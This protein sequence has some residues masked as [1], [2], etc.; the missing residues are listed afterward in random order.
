MNKGKNEKEVD[1]FGGFNLIRGEFIPPVDNN[2]EDVKDIVED[3]ITDPDKEAAIDKAIEERIRLA[4]ELKK[5]KEGKGTPKKDE[6]PE[7]DDDED[8]VGEESGIRLFARALAEKGVID[9]DDTD[10]DF[11]DAEEGLEKLVEKTINS[12]I[13]NWSSS[14]DPE[15][16][17]FYE[18]T[19]AG[20]KPQ[21]FLKV[22]YG[23]NDWNNFSIDD[24]DNQKTVVREALRLDKDLS[25]EDIEDMVEEWFDNGSLEKRA[26]SYKNKL[27]K[28][29]ESQKEAV[30]KQQ[31]EAVQRQQAEA[32][33]YWEDFKKDVYSKDEISGFKLN[34]KQKDDLW[35]FMSTV[36]KKSGK[37]SYQKAVES[38]QDST[39]LFA[40]LA[41]N[42]FDISKLEDQVSSKVAKG[43]ATKLRNIKDSRDKISGGGNNENFDASAFA[44][45]KASKL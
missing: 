26:K 3:P 15:F 33:K 16:A 22:Y 19:Q 23:D 5:T 1:P 35:N 28:Y 9:F 40:Y 44:A 27:V 38:N 39:L 13:A 30:V 10:E 42:N 8:E 29:Q 41:M 11:E 31:K 36:D 43:Y 4:E 14:L 12:R 7:P 18:F 24:E 25:T 32:Q 2:P 17:A 37:T 45:F 21:D 6:T 34:K 20:G